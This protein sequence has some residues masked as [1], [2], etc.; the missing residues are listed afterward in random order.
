MKFL[1]PLL[2]V[3]LIVSLA[4]AAPEPHDFA[5]MPSCEVLNVK[6]GDTVVL[7]LNGQETT[8]RLVGVNTPETVHPAK[9]VEAYGHEASRFLKNLLKGEEVYFEPDSTGTRL[10]RYGRT[11]GYL[12]RAPDGLFVNLEIVRQGYGH[13]YTEYP[14]QY[15]ELFREH[16]RHAREVGKGL[17]AEAEVLP[18]RTVTGRL[19]GRA[20]A[21]VAPIPSAAVGEN[22]EETVYVTRTG[23]K[24]HRAGCRH[25]AKSAIPMPLGEAKLRYEPCKTCGGSV[26]GRK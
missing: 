1:P 20:S 21:S 19:S 12:Y 26:T 11:L 18:L 9:P 17:W 22:A 25:L 5:A 6:D 4:H 13:A 8:V 2:A 16:E 10:D 7:L 3:P 24:Y 15:A 14:F 23:T